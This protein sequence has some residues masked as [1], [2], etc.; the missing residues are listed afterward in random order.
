MGETRPFDL[1]VGEVLEHWTPVFAIREVVANALDEHVLTGTE[2]PTIIRD[3]AGT[4]HVR[5]FGRGLR[6]ENLMQDESAEKLADGRVIGQFGFG[7]KDALAVLDRIGAEVMIRSRHGDISLERRPKSG[8]A[9]VVTLHAL[10]AEPSDP[11]MVGTDFAIR[12][13]TAEQVEAA[14]ELFLAYQHI[15]VLERTPFGEVLAK[16]T[17]EPG[18]VYVKGLSIAS[19]ENFLFSYNVTQLTKPLRRA[20]NRERTNVGRTAYTDRVKAI[21]LACRSAEVGQPLADDLSGHETGSLHDE[22]KWEDVA[23]HAARIL[24]STRNVVFVS[25]RD[26]R[27]NGALVEYARSDGNDIIQMPESIAAKVSGA[28]DIDGN[29]MLDI[30][31]YATEL[32]ASFQYEF[33]PETSLTDSERA[34]FDIAPAVFDLIGVPRPGMG[35]IREIRVSATMRLGSVGWDA[36]GIW[37]PVR[38]WII[39]ARRTL[40]N[41]ET[42]LG[43]L[44]HEICHARSGASDL[45]LEF[46][47][48]LS[49]ALGLLA[50]VAVRSPRSTGTRPG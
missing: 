24:Q 12:G 35:S 17:D 48:D 40:A 46:E 31:Q 1:N 10:V 11:L 15:R 43:T 29:P 39:V 30:R 21:L 20:L 23:L 7:L 49:M 45:T 13:V 36:D 3:D 22:L 5:D 6:H 42:F 50:E 32:N 28:R 14:Q 37:D 26:I 41:R 33:I 8:F 44:I 4:W 25:S 47:S 9:D 27:E 34:V 18:H 2:K 16:E 19:E 38:M